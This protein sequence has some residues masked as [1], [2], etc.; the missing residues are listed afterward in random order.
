MELL[1][2]I[3]VFSIII[4]ATIPELITFFYNYSA[5]KEEE[6]IYLK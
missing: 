2:T 1:V 6:K 4:Y 3:C 5:L